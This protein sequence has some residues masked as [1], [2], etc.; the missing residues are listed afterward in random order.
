MAPHSSGLGDSHRGVI[1]TFPQGRPFIP[2]GIVPCGQPLLPAAPARWHTRN[3]RCSWRGPVRSRAR[4]GRNAGFVQQALRKRIAVVTVLSD[5]G[6]NVKRAVGLYRHR[7][8][9]FPGRAPSNHAVV[10]A[11]ACAFINLH[12]FRVK[13]R[14]SRMLR[15]GGRANGQTGCQFFDRGQQ[16]LGHNHPAQAPADH[17]KIF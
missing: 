12:H 17:V 13:A 15:Q 2:P 3:A 4:H 1:A 14:E 10:S 7:Q 16:C 6:V 8:P 9:D 5:V 11:T